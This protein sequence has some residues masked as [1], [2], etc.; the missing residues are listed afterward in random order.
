MKRFAILISAVFAA[1]AASACCILP[2]ILGAARA[3]SVGLGAALAPY[4]PY[5]MGLTLLL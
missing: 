5:L 4:R 2:L 3:G 1:I